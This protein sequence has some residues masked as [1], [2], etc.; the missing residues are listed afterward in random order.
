MS[1][2]HLTSTTKSRM[3]SRAAWSALLLWLALNGLAALPFLDRMTRFKVFL[4]PAAP[5][6]FA[7]LE[8]L[9]VFAAW[10]RYRHLR[11]QDTA[12]PPP[13]GGFDA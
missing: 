11:A 12:G 8:A 5:T 4:N 10:L 3:P 13:H 6:M 9:L 7:V 1:V 2:D